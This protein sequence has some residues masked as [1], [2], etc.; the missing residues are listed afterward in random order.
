MPMREVRLG[1]LESPVIGRT[2]ALRIA[3]TARVFPRL[4]GLPKGQTGPVL[5]ACPI[6]S[7][8]VQRKG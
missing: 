3:I 4:S 8:L 2:G 6:S 1:T 5:T 7:G